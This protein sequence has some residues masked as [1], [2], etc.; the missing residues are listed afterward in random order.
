MNP[1]NLAGYFL[2]IGP[3]VMM[4][5]WMLV[6][7]QLIG[8]V[9]S[10]LIDEEKVRARMELG[11]ENFAVT[12][13]VATASVMGMMAMLFGYTFWARSLQ[14]GE[15]KLGILGT[16][17]ALIMPV[18]AAAILLTTDFNFA[19]GFAMSEGDSAVALATAL[20]GDAIYFGSTSIWAFLILGV[21]LIGLASAVQSVDKVSKIIGGILAVLA[22]L[23]FVFNLSTY[24]PDMLFMLWLL[25]T[26]ISGVNLIRLRIE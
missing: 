5:I 24:E 21:G 25:V 2:A 6:W 11:M 10:N 12:K 20:V 14:G 26:V 18:V 13:I 9:D 22:V 7:P 1:R 3:I 23:M 16:L 4:A 17:A 19:A 15:K 8:T